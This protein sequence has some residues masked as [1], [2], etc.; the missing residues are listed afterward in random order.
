MSIYY[1]PEFV[2]ILMQERITEAQAA[3]LTKVLEDDDR[4]VQADGLMT[5]L[6]RL[7]SRRSIVQS[8]E[9]CTSC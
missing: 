8:P 9:P 5:R 1:N 2:R 4:L 6:A 7:A 3:H